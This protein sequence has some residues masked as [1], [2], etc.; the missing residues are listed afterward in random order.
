M[1]QK[2][3]LIKRRAFLRF[4]R[5]QIVPVIIYS[6]V[7][8]VTVTIPVLASRTKVAAGTVTGFVAVEGTVRVPFAYV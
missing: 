6:T 1:I 8:G 2:A 3:R 7:P 5:D 4:E